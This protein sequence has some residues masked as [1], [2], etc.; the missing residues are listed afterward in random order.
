M[1]NPKEHFRQYCKKNNMRYTPER[2][3]IIDQIYK[4]HSHFNVDNLFIQIRKQY[5]KTKLARGSVY[6]T[7]PH[8]INSGLLRESL[9]E[10]SRICYEHTL[11]HPHHDHLKCLECGRIFEFYDQSIDKKQQEICKNH[12]FIMKSRLHI[13]Y[14]YCPYCKKRK[15]NKKCNLKK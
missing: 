1:M 2:A 8:L 13:I 11:G 10:E 15:L 14:G 5:P 9:T 12:K 3:F 4:I 7:I 6:R